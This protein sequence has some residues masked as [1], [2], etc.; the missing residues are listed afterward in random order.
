MSER[1][2]WQRRHTV[3]AVL[4]VTWIISFVDRIAISVAIPYIA[5]DYDLSPVEMGVVLSAFFGGYSLMQIPGGLLADRFG[6]RKVAS[7]AMIFWSAMTAITGAATN[8]S[9]LVAARFL[10]G[11]GEGLFPA[12]A[13]KS[14]AV[15]FPR[16][17]RARANAR[18][19]AP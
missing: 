6:V 10:F 12:C 1:F 8:L 7:L 17:E 5:E 4:F 9:Q 15:W 2:R 19:P 16:E 13:F 14:I 3:L 11:L 18:R